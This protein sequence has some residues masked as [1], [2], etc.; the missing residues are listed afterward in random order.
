MN[1]IPEKF[2]FVLVTQVYV[3]ERNGNI[4][5]HVSL[6]IHFR[7]SLFLPWHLYRR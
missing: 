6:S 2:A 5:Q 3:L 7:H 1:L 4:P